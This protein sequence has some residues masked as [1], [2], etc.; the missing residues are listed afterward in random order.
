MR[1]ILVVYCIQVKVASWNPSQWTSSAELR[2]GVKL[3]IIANI[4]CILFSCSTDRLS[5]CLKAS[6]H[7]D[8]LGYIID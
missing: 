1:A 3:L 5:L 7:E 4:L 2:K 6:D 8:S